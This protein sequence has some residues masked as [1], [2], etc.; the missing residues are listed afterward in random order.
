[1][2]TS[3]QQL[4]LAFE[5]LSSRGATAV[6]TLDA[7]SEIA[8]GAKFHLDR[9]S[10]ERSAV[11]AEAQM[12]NTIEYRVDCQLLRFLHNDNNLGCRFPIGKVDQVI[13]PAILPPP[14][15]TLGHPLLAVL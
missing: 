5:G 13:P 10:K 4:S 14:V 7:L 6:Q 15:K 1:M 3:C 8:F 2:S 9:I 11:V 12:M